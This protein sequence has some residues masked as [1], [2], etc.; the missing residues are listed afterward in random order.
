MPA[1]AVTSVYSIGPEGRGG[2]GLADGEGAAACSGVAEGGA[3]VTG[4]LQPES[5]TARHNKIKAERKFFRI[6]WRWILAARLDAGTRTR[7]RSASPPVQPG[8]TRTTAR[9]PR[10]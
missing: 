5:N 8:T 3:T 1:S 2:V 10:D 6:M 7:P 9:A 4:C